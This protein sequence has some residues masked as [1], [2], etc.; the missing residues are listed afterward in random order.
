MTTGYDYYTEDTERDF[1][2]EADV[3]RQAEREGAEELAAERAAA[4]TS[5][6]AA[7][8]T[9]EFAADYWTALEGN[10]MLSDPAIERFRDELAERIG[11]M[12]GQKVEAGEPDRWPV[13]LYRDASL[14]RSVLAG[15]GVSSSAPRAIALAIGLQSVTLHTSLRSG[16]TV[17]TALFTVPVQ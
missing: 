16:D 13:V 14:I 17:N 8:A 1:E 10:W 11:H 5:T 15:H 9:A 2:E 4:G 3:R 12:L 7:Y 6:P